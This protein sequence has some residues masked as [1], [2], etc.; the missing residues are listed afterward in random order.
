MNVHPEIAFYAPLKAPDH[1]VPSGDRTMARLWFKALEQSGFAPCQQG[2]LRSYDGSGDETRQKAIRQA[3]LAE[4]ETLIAYHLSRKSADRPKLWFTYHV[5]YKAPDWIGPVVADAL[6]IPYVIAEGSRAPKRAGG[7][8]AIGHEGAEQALDRADLIL[9]MT[10]TDEETLMRFRPGN[11]RIVKFPPFIDLGE[12]PDIAGTRQTHAPPRF[13]AVA[14]MR[15]GDKLESFRQLAEALHLIAP[16]WQID[17]VGDGATRGE[18]ERLFAPFGQAVTMH[19]EI[20]ERFRLAELYQQADLLLWPAVNEAYGMIFLEAQAF[21]CPVVA[22]NQGGVASVVMHG[23]TGFL[24]TKNDPRIFADT[25]TK[26]LAD[27]DMHNRFSQQAR[28][29]IKQRRSLSS[30]I[31]QLAPLMESTLQGNGT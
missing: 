1:P 2:G 14:M 16:P 18:I 25:V 8:W 19:G 17:I 22:G 7:P 3:A 15:Q 5:Y 23:E 31:K 29:F 4:A 9:A 6:S 27:G 30:A 24:V 21:G 28:L 11:Q 12:W 10:E 20:T 26:L 13:L